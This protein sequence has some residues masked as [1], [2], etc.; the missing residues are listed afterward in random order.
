MFKKAGLY[1]MPRPKSGTDL[2]PDSRTLHAVAKSDIKDRMLQL[3]DVAR[4]YT[5][6][7]GMNQSVT[8]IWKAVHSLR[9]AMEVEHAE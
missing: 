9:R 4:K 1:F 6:A 7:P 5:G 2:F 3:R 8:H